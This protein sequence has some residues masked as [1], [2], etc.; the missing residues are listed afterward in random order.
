M[1]EKTKEWTPDASQQYV[2]N[3]QEGQHLVLAAPGCGKTQILTERIRKALEQGVAVED[4]LCLTFTNRAARG[5]MERIESHI[6]GNDI[7]NIYVGNVHRLCF[8]F[9][10]ENQL[11]S[12]ES[13]TLDEEDSISILAHYFDEDEQWVL[14]SPKKKKEYS[15]IIFLSHLMFQ[16]AHQ[17]PKNLRLH[18]DC[19]DN[20]DV[21]ALQNICKMQQMDFTPQT[22]IDIYEH[23]DVYE[24]MLR[25]DLSDYATLVSI[26]H[27]LRKMRL[28]RH[29]E[30]Y[31]KTNKL[32][33]F[34][35]LLLLA[36]EALRNAKENEYKHYNWIQVDEVQDLN[37]LQLAIIDAITNKENAT[38]M[39]LGDEQQA[40]FSFMGAKLDTLEMLRKRCGTNVHHLSFNHRSPKY[41]LNV[42][43]EY[44]EHILN[45]NRALLPEADNKE[46][47]TGR[48][49][50]IRSNNVPETEL[51]DIALCAG[52]LHHEFK[53]DTT[54]IIV[55]SNREADEISQALQARELAHFK[56]SGQDL[57]SMPEVKLLFTHLNLLDNEHNFIAWARLLKGLQVVGGNTS[58]RNLVQSLIQ[59]SMLPSDLLQ[60][61]NSSY[62]CEFV[63]IFDTR[64]FVVF[65]TETTGLNVFEDDIVQI[66]AVKMRQG[67]IVPDSRF[68]VFIATERSIPQMLGNISNPILKE[69]EHNTRQNAGQALHAFIEYVGNA[70]LIAHN[71]NYDYHI[72]DY[73]LQ[74]YCPEL[75]LKELHPSY[76]DSLKII[77][78]LCPNLR[79]YKLKALLETLHLQGENSHLADED[80]DATV[81]LVNYCYERALNII[82]TQREFMNK[83]RVKECAHLLRKRYGELYHIA[84]QQLYCCQPAPKEPELVNT[85]QTFY[86]YLCTERLIVPFAHFNYIKTY[87]FAEFANAQVH[88]SLIT[89]LSFCAQKIN[90]LKEADLCNTSIINERIFVTTIHKAKGLEFDNVIIPDVTDGRYP[91]YYNQTNER[92]VSE[93]A[94]K[95]Y[96]AL[97]R[98]KKRIIITHSLAK[99]TY[100]GFLRPCNPSRFLTPI[101]RFFHASPA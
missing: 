62:I 40:I 27:T 19:L 18:A 1:K 21:E 82:H 10:F 11:I 99:P 30:M 56:V 3:L 33:D 12:A 46:L 85:L 75:N 42:F 55:S 32:I 25:S 60:Y 88:P 65:D 70:I 72:L 17:H 37:P 69:L 81:N 67:K 91:N 97:T 83:T 43:N 90:T 79:Q 92:L 15:N 76:F 101:L 98:A 66:A 57:F 23:T 6:Q 77:R 71:A 61:T 41:L 7:S 94:R 13:S 28:A 45:I 54:A 39:F 26:T 68:N 100:N 63:N 22:M 38:I 48:E 20:E 89:Q 73:N 59:R 51:Q 87:F 9:L 96:V 34:E 4:M 29:Y 8:K 14:S 95:L 5:M 80:V 74:R 53:D 78:L 36:Y 58:A 16:I 44:A 93:D 50:Q 49:L 64:E 84:R 47:G 52:N 86:D 2:I 24:D 31:K 35:D